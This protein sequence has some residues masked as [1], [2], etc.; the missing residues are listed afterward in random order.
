[1]KLSANPRMKGKV[2]K[3]QV[4]TIEKLNAWR[5]IDIEPKDAFAIITEDGFATTCE[6]TSGNRKESNFASR[7]LFMID[8]DDGMTIQ[9]LLA[10]DFYNQYALGFYA[11]ASFTPEHH[12]FRILFMTA[13]PIMTAKESRYITRALRK[14]Y[15]QSD[16]AC[17]DPARLFYGCVN[18]EI[19]EYTGKV[20]PNDLVEQL[21]ELIAAEDDAM[22][23][24]MANQPKVDYT[25]TDE[26]K[27][28]ILELLRGCFV[29]N[30]PIW[31]NIGWG[32]KSGGFSLQDFQFVTQGL[33]R[34]KTN[35]DAAKV[36]NDGSVNGAVTMGSVIHFLK[37]RLGEECL[38]DND[39]KEVRKL[40]TLVNGLANKYRS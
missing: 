28:R 16:P 32:L 3:T 10:D 36:W 18:C 9:E 8:I 35:Q 7:Q 4:S 15:P 29:G 40:S 20:M 5:S 19:K 38:R 33:M 21:I 24:A 23:E 30:Y 34:Q 14:I 12:K 39:E 27:Q 6:L 2:D 37:S 17:V 1:M 13:E 22:A 11:T 31:R 25:M 26:R